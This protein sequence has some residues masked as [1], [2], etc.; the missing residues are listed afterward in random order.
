MIINTWYIAGFC[1]EVAAGTPKAVRMLGHDFVLFRDS[2]GKVHC[3]SDVCIHR[4]GSLCRGKMVGDTVMCPYHGWRFDGAGACVDIPSVGKDLPI[5]KRARV[6]SYPTAEQWG[7]VWVFLG[8]LPEAERPP[9]P[10]ADFFPEWDNAVKWDNSGAGAYRIIRGSFL[11]DVNWMRAIDNVLDPAHPF[12]V[13]SEFGH[14]E[15]QRIKAFPVD[16]DGVKT[17]SRHSFRSTAKHGAWR[18]VMNDDR[19]PTRNSLQ[20]HMSGLILRNDIHPNPGMHHCVFSAYLPIEHNKT[21]NIWLHARNFFTEPKYDA[22]TIKRTLV[23]FEEDARVLQYVRPAQ[24]PRRLTHE[25][26]LEADAHI[27]AFRRQVRAFED[28][29][30]MLDHRAAAADDEEARV[31]P[32]P[33]RRADPKNWV[34]DPAITRRTRAAAAE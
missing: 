3:L 5:P 16:D 1:D 24:S 19:P 33:A 20:F 28:K 2:A 23:V 31:I 12:H 34:L 26:F 29:G 9:I 32:S 14:V 21:L 17:L 11:F 27:A 10:G 30:W 8:D 7:W 25:L 18:Q 15:D 4:G 22:D 6:D 13:H